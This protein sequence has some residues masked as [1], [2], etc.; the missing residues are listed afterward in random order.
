MGFV[1]LCL[2]SPPICTLAEQNH[3]GQP[4]SCTHK[5]NDREWWETGPQPKGRSRFAL[6]LESGDGIRYHRPHRNRQIS[7]Q[8]PSAPRR[9]C[10]L[11]VFGCAGRAVEIRA[12]S[13]IT[14]HLTGS[15]LGQGC[16][17]PLVKAQPHPAP[18]QA[19]TSRGPDRQRGPSCSQLRTPLAAVQRHE[20]NTAQRS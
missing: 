13:A 7:D 12:S 2:C 18:R 5:P 17:V 14:D 9:L 20:P 6:A 3:V 8:H 1:S 11:R 16:S 15:R 19:G 10:S 4:R